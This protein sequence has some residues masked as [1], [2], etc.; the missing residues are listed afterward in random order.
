[1]YQSHR[2]P[3]EQGFSLMELL[4]VIAIIGIL[5]SIVVVSLQAGIRSA[6]ETAAIAHLDTIRKGQTQYALSHKGEYGT[7]DQLIKAGY[8]DKEFAG[9]TPI[10]KG[11]VF[12]MKITP[13]SANQPA[14]FSVNAD[15]QQ[16]DGVG[17]TGS[18]YFYI[19]PNVSTV[20]Q[21]DQGPAGPNDPGI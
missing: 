10:V 17:A 16:A 11:Y 21:N 18:R 6:N 19:D 7:F 20:R 1:M 13:K 3:R 2:R 5:A 15:P 12:T 4:I 9:E 14:S 8:L